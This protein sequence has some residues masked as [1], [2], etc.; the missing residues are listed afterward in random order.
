[1]YAEAGWDAGLDGAQLAAVVHGDD[2]LVIVAGAGTGKTRTLTARVARLLDRGVA[3]E[4]ILLLTFTRRAADDM[5]ARAAAL[6]GHREWGRRLRAVP[7]TLSPISSSAA[8]QSRSA[9]NR[10]SRSSIP[11]M[12]PT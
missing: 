8:A 4:K 10:G 9:C 2:P 5:L 1:M 6:I 7:F 12:P 3:P 11:P